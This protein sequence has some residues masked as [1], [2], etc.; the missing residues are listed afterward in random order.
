M[1]SKKPVFVGHTSELEDFIICDICEKEANYEKDD[2]HLV[3][4]EY[5]KYVEI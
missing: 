1:I 5:T 2:V 3:G 4:I